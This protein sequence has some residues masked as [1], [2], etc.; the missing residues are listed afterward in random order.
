MIWWITDDY[1][2]LHI[3][4]KQLDDASLNVIRV[5]KRIGIILNTR[6]SIEECF[7]ST[8]KYALRVSP[9][10]LD[11]LKPDVA[12]L[13]GKA[14]G[15]RVFA[16]GVFGAIHTA[17]RE[18]AGELRDADTKHLSGQYVIDAR[19]QVGNLLRQARREA[20][21]DLAEEHARLGAGVEKG[22]RAVGPQVGPIVAGRPGLGKGVEH[23]LGEVGRGED[24]VVGQVGD[25]GE[26]IGVATPQGE[27]DL[28]GEGIGDVVHGFLPSSRRAPAS[29]SSSFI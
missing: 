17:P 11:S 8:T 7:W 18:Q 12:R 1:V 13:A 3:V 14:F 24:L 6:I 15:N 22:D 27:A 4:S 21:G 5:N 19:L 20:A 29:A 10:M 26:H 25:A 16:I 28:L 2:E 9:R 23:P